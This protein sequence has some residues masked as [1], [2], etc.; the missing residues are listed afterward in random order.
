M[1]DFDDS[2]VMSWMHEIGHMVRVIHSP[3]EKITYPSIAMEL[4]A[5]YDLPDTTPSD[6]LLEMCEEYLQRYSDPFHGLGD[7][8]VNLRELTEHGRNALFA[9]VT[10]RSNL[11]KAHAVELPGRDSHY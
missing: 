9:A 7:T 8:S 11:L 2:E 6:E 10:A 3:Y 4:H 1:I 5:F